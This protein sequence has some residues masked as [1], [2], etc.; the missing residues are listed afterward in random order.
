[1][2]LAVDVGNTETMLGVFEG[3][4]AVHCWRISTQRHPTGDEMCITLKGLL[5]TA[6]MGGGTTPERAIIA[7]VVPQID[8]SWDQALGLIG[9]PFVRIDGRSRLPI[10]L[11]VDEPSSVGADRIANTLATSCLFGRNTVVVDLG[12]ATTFDCISADGVFLGGVIAPGPL[13]GIERLHQVASKLP[14]VDIRCPETVIGRFTEACLESG[15][16]YSIVDGIDGVVRRIL[17]EW[18]PEDPL[19]IATGGLAE[20]LAPHCETVERVSPFL[21]LLGLVCA[22]EHLGSTGP[23]G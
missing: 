12:T 6:P 13:A 15:V 10:R 1:M 2:I 14:V 19:V 17:E 22:D 7:S 16:F 18:K 9:I 20:L 3:R 5:A 21:T 4:E 8:R 23:V 11:D